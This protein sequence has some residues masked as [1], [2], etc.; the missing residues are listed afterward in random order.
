MRPSK[1]F[2]DAKGIR[3]KRKPN[4]LVGVD[5]SGS[6]SMDELNDFLVKLIISTDL[7]LR[8]L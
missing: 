2:P 1:R 7:A 3:L 6:V 8:S 5:T 4:I